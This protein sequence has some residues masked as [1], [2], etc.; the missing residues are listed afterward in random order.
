M[1]AYLVEGL[2]IKEAG[3]QVGFT[4]AA[5]GNHL[6]RFGIT[7]T[8]RE[9]KIRRSGRDQRWLD[10]L[11][12]L[13]QDGLSMNEIGRQLGVNSGTVHYHLQRRN[14]NLDGNLEHVDIRVVAR[15][16][17]ALALSAES[18]NASCFHLR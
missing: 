12:K 14:Q 4:E 11:V 15:I 3:R 8:S 6:R 5:A 13:H 1:N 7:R 10:R 9:S 18:Q 17:G 16:S 2:T